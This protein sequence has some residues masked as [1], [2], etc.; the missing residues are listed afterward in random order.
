M[1]N[2]AT[3]SRAKS[4]HKEVTT[5]L[6]KED[7]IVAHLMKILIIIKDTNFLITSRK[8][9]KELITLRLKGKRG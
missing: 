6:V 3:N 4:L 5:K 9:Y 7:L 2:R 8:V 1:A